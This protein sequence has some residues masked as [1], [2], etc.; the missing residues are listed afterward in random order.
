MPA[1]QRPHALNGGG[2]YIAGDGDDLVF[3]GLTASLE[4][5]DGG[6]GVDYTRYDDL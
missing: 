2:I 5:L 1:R 3:A 6:T 4:T